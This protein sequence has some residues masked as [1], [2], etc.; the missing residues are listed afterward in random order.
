MDNVPDEHG[1]DLGSRWEADGKRAG[2]EAIRE[3]NSGKSGAQNEKMRGV[4]QESTASICYQ[5]RGKKRL[6]TCCMYVS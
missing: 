5:I 6:L 2:R 4:V 1:K 3:K